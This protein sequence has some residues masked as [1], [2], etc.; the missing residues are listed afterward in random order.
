[1]MAELTPEQFIENSTWVFAKTMPD[2]P[3]Q[4]TLRDPESKAPAMSP[5]SFVWFAQHIRGE[6]Y[7]A[8]FGKTTYTY[9]EVGPYRYW[10]MGWPVEQTT[11][12]NRAR[13]DGEPALN[14]NTRGFWASWRRPMSP[15]SP[16]DWLYL[17]VVPALG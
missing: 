2:S 9:L 11:L 5:E 8:K 3:H 13:I 4:Y 10:T 1:M 16:D 12:I 17:P 14:P 6:G 15:T 7:K